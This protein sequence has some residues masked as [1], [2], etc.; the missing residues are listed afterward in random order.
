MAHLNQLVEVGMCDVRE[1]NEGLS[2]LLPLL[3]ALLVFQEGLKLL[4]HLSM[5]LLQVEL[6]LPL[7]AAH[8]L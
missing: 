4:L 3:R 7:P 2:V 8:I 6:G 5:Q 1:T